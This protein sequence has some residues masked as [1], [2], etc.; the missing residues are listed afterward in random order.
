M[1]GPEV[2]CEVFDRG[3]F[4]WLDNMQAADIITHDGHGTHCRLCDS[5]KV[6]PIEEHV[7]KHRAQW[8]AYKLKKEARG[9]EKASETLRRL[10]AERRLM[11]DL[12]AL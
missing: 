3:S 2:W 7:E 12:G 9:R 10:N 6:F 1:T 11:K 4:R 8:R 5:Y